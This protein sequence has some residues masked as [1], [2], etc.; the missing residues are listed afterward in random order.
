MFTQNKIRVFVRTVTQA[1][2]QL[3]VMTKSYVT[4]RGIIENNCTVLSI[5]TDR[6]R[7][8]L[9]LNGE[10]GISANCLRQKMNEIKSKTG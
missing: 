3:E 8:C 7:D 1:A 6:K 2:K 4:L 10:E 5:T 9:G